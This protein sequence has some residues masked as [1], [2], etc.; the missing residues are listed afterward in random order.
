M[1]YS[2]TDISEIMWLEGINEET[3]IEE[4]TQSF[5]DLERKKAV[6]GYFAT[7]CET[8]YEFLKNNIYN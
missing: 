3:I 5:N 8:S 4:W 7:S 2:P 1:H 6:W